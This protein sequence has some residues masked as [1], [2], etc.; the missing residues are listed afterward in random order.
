M[1]LTVPR[2]REYQRYRRDR[3]APPWIAVHRKL[4]RHPR[5]VALTN[6]DRGL[7]L[8]IWML[9]ADRDGTIEAPDLPAYIAAVGCMPRPDLTTLIEAGFIVVSED[10]QHVSTTL[11]MG[12]RMCRT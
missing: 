7:L 10:G 11:V 2:W 3:G 9:A 4:L 8:Q 12:R 5:W 1:T 6:A